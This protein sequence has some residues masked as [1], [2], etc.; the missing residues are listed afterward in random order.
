[1]TRHEDA[2]YHRRCLVFSLGT[3]GILGTFG[4][5]VQPAYQVAHIDA[6]NPFMHMMHMRATSARMRGGHII[7]L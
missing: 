1:M 7:G 6:G 2:Q 3:L 5:A 4:G